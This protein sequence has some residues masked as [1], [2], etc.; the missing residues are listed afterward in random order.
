MREAAGGLRLLECLP[1][2][3]AERILL[4]RLVDRHAAE[5]VLGVPVDQLS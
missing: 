3:T 1:P 4:E 5:H 2:G